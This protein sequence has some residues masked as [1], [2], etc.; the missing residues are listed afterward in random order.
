V[1]VLLLIVALLLGVAA[2]AGAALVCVSMVNGVREQWARSALSARRRGLI[3]G[4]AVAVYVVGGAVLSIT[5]PWG[6]YS[7]LYVFG[8]GGGALMVLTMV[9]VGLGAIGEIRG[10]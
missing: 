5:A 6:S 9:G 2:I 10:T 8:F 3:A 7:V 4:A 1:S